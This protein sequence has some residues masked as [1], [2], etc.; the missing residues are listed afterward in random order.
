MIAGCYTLDLYCDKDNKNHSYNE[1][2]HT[3]I[4]EKGSDCRRAARKD[5]WILT[6]DNEAICPKCSKKRKK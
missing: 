2:P 5:G 4:A 6:R 1:F 3:Y